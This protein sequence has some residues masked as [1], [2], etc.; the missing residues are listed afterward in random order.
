KAK[1]AVLT[2]WVEMGLPWTPSAGA[3]V[4]EV[5]ANDAPP[6]H[7]PPKVTAETMRFWSFQPVRR[8]VIP[9]VKE[10]SWVRTPVD[11]FILQKLEAAGLAHAGPAGR[12]ALLRRAYYGLT[13]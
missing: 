2:K 5:A 11:A 3:G 8:P 13:G 10:V 1:I 4:A 7:V 6:K 9:A 12:A